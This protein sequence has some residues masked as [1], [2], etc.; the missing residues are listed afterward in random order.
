[1]VKK[2]KKSKH[3][4]WDSEEE[5][6]GAKAD[7]PSDESA[8]PTEGAGEDAAP[9]ASR[10]KKDKKRKKGKGKLQDDEDADAEPAAAPAE[11]GEQG[12][13][14]AQAE[15]LV[16]VEVLDVT[17]HPKLPASQRLV[18]VFDGNDLSKVWHHVSAALAST[19]VFSRQVT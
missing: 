10:K 7:Q 14:D 18:T 15:S 6:R 17:A 4:E 19:E 8:A 11:G 12:A 3:V 1:M 16:V 13:F 2:G 9:A 5:P